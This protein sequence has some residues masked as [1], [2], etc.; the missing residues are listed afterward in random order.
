MDTHDY[1]LTIQKQQKLL[2]LITKYEEHTLA[3][4]DCDTDEVPEHIDERD[5]IVKLVDVLTKEILK[6]CPEGSPEYKAFR[7]SCSRDELSPKMQQIFDL[8][9]QFN[10]HMTRAHSIDPD[11]IT[12]IKSTRDDIVKEIKENNSG[13]NANAAKFY[14][15][16]MSR[17]KNVYFPKNK[18]EI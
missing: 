18:K 2:F 1:V 16:S 3:L 15:N 14:T 11:V 12:R 5:R 9:Q 4:L 6:I 10:T 13:Q 17:G 8:R 7:N